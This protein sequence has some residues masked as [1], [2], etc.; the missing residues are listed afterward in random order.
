MLPINTRLSDRAADQL[1]YIQQQ[2]EQELAEILDIAI[3]AY[4][5]KLQMEKRKRPFELLEQSGFIGCCS[6]EED[7]SNNY[8]SVLHS[9]L[10]AKY[11]HR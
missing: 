7:L 9:E 11:D 10:Q 3:D 8:K 4:Y 2:T 5:Q 1:A 6:V